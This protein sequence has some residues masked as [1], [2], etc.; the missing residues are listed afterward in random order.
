MGA[1]VF[2]PTWPRDAAE[3]QLI[4]V[5]R[6]IHVGC[7]ALINPLRASRAGLYPS[8]RRVIPQE[9]PC[10]WC[11]RSGWHVTRQGLWR[12]DFGEVLS[13][14][15]RV[16]ARANHARSGMVSGIVFGDESMHDL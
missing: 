9:P 13:A 1:L 11:D 16:C 3:Q 4:V 10:R 5:A 6:D 12:D 2:N 8:A 15:R 7:E 14:D